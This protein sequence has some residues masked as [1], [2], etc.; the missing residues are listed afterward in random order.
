MAM[1]LADIIVGA[2]VQM[3]AKSASHLAAIY[4]VQ[5]GEDFRASPWYMEFD[6]IIPPV[7]DIVLDLALP[8]GLIGGGV[9]LKNDKMTGMGVGAAISGIAIFTHGLIARYG[10]SVTAQEETAA[11]I[12]LP[13]GK[14]GAPKQIPGVL[15]PKFQYGNG[16]PIGL[17]TKARLAGGLYPGY[18]MVARGYTMRRPG[19]TEAVGARGA[20]NVGPY[21]GGIVAL[22][23]IPGHLRP[24]Y[25]HG[26]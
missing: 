13:R 23:F 18:G 26:A 1:D 17:G 4:L 9:A 11:R 25:Q 8:A 5:Q 7:D 10:D 12:G 6:P 21:A 15:M 16:N 14:Y 24:K 20:I 22:K 2:A 19:L 3:A